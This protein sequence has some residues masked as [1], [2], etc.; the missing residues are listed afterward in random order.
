M[1][2]LHKFKRL[3]RR[4][5]FCCCL[6]LSLG[7]NAQNDVHNTQFAFNKLAY[8]PAYAGSHDVLTSTA[9]YRNQWSGVEGAPKTLSLSG[10]AP[11][12]N[13]R[14]G[15][16][17]NLTHDQLGIMNSTYVDLSYAYKVPLTNEMVLSMAVSGRIGNITSDWS[18]AK[19]VD[20]GDGLVPLQRE[21]L[22]VRNFGAGAYL[23]TKRFYAGISMPGILKASLYSKDYQ[24]EKSMQTMYMMSGYVMNLSR[25]VKFKPS[26]LLSFN[27]SAPTALDLNAN[28]LFL[29]TLWL[30][31]SYRIGDSIDGIVMYQFSKQLKAGLAL[32]FTITELQ[33]YS[34]GNF[35]LLMEYGFSFDNNKI[36]NL[37][38]F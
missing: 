17:L 38:Y 30:G 11:L 33:K 15:I 29:E 2:I 3:K 8:N 13:Q 36:N 9:I 24:S 34:N 35:E 14:C 31:A 20:N 28:F 32:D 18:E 37:R 1:K 12:L 16:G 23:H 7:A 10:H 26:I 22:L 4:S 19:I 5:A 6:I 27:P 21:S 25:N